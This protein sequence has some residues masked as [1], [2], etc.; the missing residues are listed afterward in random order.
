MEADRAVRV[1]V[2]FA[3]QSTGTSPAR[4]C[5]ACVE[6]LQVS[7]AGITVMSGTNSGPVCASNE[8]TEVLEELQFVLGEGPC[9]DA[10]VTGDPQS[11]ADLGSVLTGRWPNYTPTALEAGARGVFAFPLG[12]G[13]SRIGV[14]T[15]YQDTAVGLTEQQRADSLVVA[16]VVAQT[17]ITLQASGRSGV[18]PSDLSDTGAHRAEV[19]QA[20]GMVAVQLGVGVAEALDRIRAHAYAAGRM[21]AAVAEDIVGGHLRLADD[22]ARGGAE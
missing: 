15:L 13:K 19:H 4:L 3:R 8:R 1:A 10:Y 7:G 5:K 22:R 11:V 18:L 12:V 9:R 14:L 6:V 2:A 21:V 17:M 20:T 16:D